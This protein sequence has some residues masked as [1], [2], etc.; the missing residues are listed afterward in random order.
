MNRGATCCWRVVNGFEPACECVLHLVDVAPPAMVKSLSSRSF[1]EEQTAAVRRSWAVLS[2]CAGAKQVVVRAGL[3]VSVGPVAA[4]EQDAE[5]EDVCFVVVI[6]VV[7]ALAQ[8]MD[9]GYTPTLQPQRCRKNQRRILERNE[10]VRELA[11]RLE[12]LGWKVWR[13]TND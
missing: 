10:L 1:V 8:A 6:G 13:G 12:T 7:P 9:N 11:D 5:V 2:Q 3:G 4:V